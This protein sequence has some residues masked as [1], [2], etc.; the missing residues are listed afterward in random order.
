M[1]GGKTRIH[2]TPPLRDCKPLETIR[3]IRLSTHLHHITRR[4]YT[5]SRLDPMART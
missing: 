2:F 3:P 1:I 4:H 5:T